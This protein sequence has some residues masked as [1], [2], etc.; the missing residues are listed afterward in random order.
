MKCGTLLVA[1]VQ[2]TVSEFD[3]DRSFLVDT[4]G[5]NR[6]GQF[7]EY[8]PLQSSLNRTSTKLRVVTFFRDLTNR[9]VR[10]S[11]VNTVVLKHLM[12]T[13]YL[14]A[15]NIA[16]LRLVQRREDYRFI[17][18]VEELRTDSLT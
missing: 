5:D 9:I 8:Q 18:T 7:V 13:G 2:F 1:E 12:N 10:N 4:T 14:Q 16:Y 15:D 3:D 17:Y 11:Q 6:L